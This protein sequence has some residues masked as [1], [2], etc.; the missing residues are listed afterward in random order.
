[1]PC[2]AI[3]SPAMPRWNRTRALPGVRA[4]SVTKASRIMPKS[5]KIIQRIGNLRCVK[6]TQ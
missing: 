6:S 5:T 4:V 3:H 2:S 1:M